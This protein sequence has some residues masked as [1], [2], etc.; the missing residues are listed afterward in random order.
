MDFVSKIFIGSLEVPSN[1]WMAPMVDYTFLPFRRLVQ[2]LGAGL[3]FT[4]MVHAEKLLQ[5]DPTMARRIL[6][7]SQ[8]PIKAVQLVGAQPAL[9]EQ[10]CRCEL[11]RDADIMDINMACPNLA[12]VQNGGGCALTEDLPRAARIIEG[13]KRSGKTVTVKCR[14]GMRKNKIMI[15]PFAR[16]CEAAGADAL[17]VHG[18]T[19]DMD[20]SCP[21]DPSYIARAKAVVSIPVIANGDITS[22]EDAKSLMAQ[23]HA[24]GVMI[25]RQALKDP[26]LFARMTGRKFDRRALFAEQVVLLAQL[27]HIYDDP[28]YLQNILI[29]FLP[30]EK[31][32]GEVTADIRN[33]FC[34]QRFLDL[35]EALL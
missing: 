29:A 6:T 22:G 14:P 15:E 19:L 30:E 13:C 4:E 5:K 16:M 1:V 27:E 3:A 34:H 7:D 18:R 8:E 11:L 28:R 20:Y 12:V 23:T 26:F 35:A 10:V 9:M 2:R 33:T 21:S 32:T 17:I 31:R 25:A 24:D